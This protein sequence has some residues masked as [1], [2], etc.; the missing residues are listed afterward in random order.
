MMLVKKILIIFFFLIPFSNS[1]AAMVTQIDKRTFR[2]PGSA[3]KMGTVQFNDDGT[4]MFLT[5]HN[6]L[7][8]TAAHRSDDKINEYT[9]SVP[10]DISTATYAGNDERCSVVDP[11]HSSSHRSTGAT[12]GF[13][14]ANDGMKIFTMQRGL[15]DKQTSFVNRLDL[16]TAY[17]ISTC[18]YHSDV[19]VD[20]NALQN[21]TN[22]GDRSTDN[23]NNLQGMFI[24]ND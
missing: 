21:G 15:N 3:D 19:N 22:I 5:F 24:T 4:K 13:K 12:L 6:G 11:D 7:N 14:F 2:D 8:N 1:F 17:D 23:N 16:T 18:T 9:L 20:T 10:Y